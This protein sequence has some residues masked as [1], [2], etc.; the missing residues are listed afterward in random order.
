MTLAESIIDHCQSAPGSFSSVLG[1]TL[2]LRDLIKNYV[3]RRVPI[4]GGVELYI[5]NACKWTTSDQA[6]GD[7]QFMFSEPYPVVYA[8]KGP[9][10]LAPEILSL[11]L[12]LRSDGIEIQASPRLAHVPL[13]SYT[14]TIDLD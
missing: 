13:P 11:T 5:P 4:S 2:N 12:H 10:G 8:S 3:G 6:N 7:V 1:T 9:I 14:V